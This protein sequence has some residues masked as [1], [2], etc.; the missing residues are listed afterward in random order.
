M[1][2]TLFNILEIEYIKIN[3]KPLVLNHAH[4]YTKSA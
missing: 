2:F 4:N 1:K 3:F